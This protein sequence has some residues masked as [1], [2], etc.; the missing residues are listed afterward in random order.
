MRKPSPATVIALVAL[1]VALGGVG[2]AATGGNFILGQSNTAT[3]PSSLSAPVAGGNALQLTNT[4]TSNAASTAL[5]LNVASGHAPFTVNTGIKVAGLNSD[6]LDGFDSAYFLPKTGTAANSAKLGGQ[7]PSYYLP[8]TGKAADSD[9]LDGLDSSYFLPASALLHVGPVSVPASVPATFVT[10]AAIGQLTFTAYCYDDGGNQ[11]VEMYVRSSVAHAV[12][13]D[14]TQA[15]AGTSW[16]KWDTV[17]DNDYPIAFS[18]VQPTGLRLFTSVTGEAVTADNHQV[19]F[20]LYMGQN[21]RGQTGNCVFGGS[22][23][24]R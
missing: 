19:S 24:V 2:M 23:A 21:A 9:K 5:G 1:F 16:S 17:A 7:L 15:E 8:K 22:F 18:G 11:W 3:T 4:D 13:A 6:K 12:F 10:L 20:D 14:L